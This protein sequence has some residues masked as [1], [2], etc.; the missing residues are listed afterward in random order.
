VNS[1][2]VEKILTDYPTRW[3]SQ[4]QAL[5]AFIEGLLSI[6]EEESEGDEELKKDMMFS[7]R[8]NQSGILASVWNFPSNTRRQMMELLGYAKLSEQVST[9][10]LDLFILSVEDKEGLILLTIRLVLYFH[11]VE[12]FAQFIDFLKEK[13][14]AWANQTSYR[15]YTDKKDNENSKQE[16]KVDSNNSV[17]MDCETFYTLFTMYQNHI[18]TLEIFLYDKELETHFGPDIHYK[19]LLGNENIFE[20]GTEKATTD[21]DNYKATLEETL[22]ARFYDAWNDPRTQKLLKEK[23]HQ[24]IYTQKLVSYRK[25]PSFDGKTTLTTSPSRLEKI[26]VSLSFLFVTL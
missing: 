14:R 17:K 8:S 25:K 7:T 5:L 15:V 19:V 9:I 6:E 4:V 23:F 12:Y 26:R 1:I 18:S 24:L 22:F 13:L 3:Q 21:M 2:D 11:F 16:G 10:H 20:Q